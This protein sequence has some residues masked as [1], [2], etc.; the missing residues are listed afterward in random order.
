[1]A[2][3]VE[4]ES[5]RSGQRNGCRRGALT[6]TNRRFGLI[7]AIALMLMLIAGCGDDGSASPDVGTTADREA[8]P[9]ADFPATVNRTLDQ[10]IRQ[11][12]PPEHTDPVITPAVQVFYPGEGR[13]SFTLAE[14][15]GTEITDADVALYIAPIPGPGENGSAYEQPARG[16]FPA[17]LVS[18]GT[19][20]EFRSKTT[21]QNPAS[22][23]AFY[24]ADIPFAAGDWRVEAL[25]RYR[26]RLIAKSLPRA[27]VGAYRGIPKAGERPPA[28]ATPTLST[29]GGDAEK[30][31]TR[32]P[33]GDM[34]RSSFA[35][36]LG[37][38][39]VALLFT[40]PALCQSRV[41]SPVA[42]V[43]EQ[44]N[45]EFAGR[46]EMIQMEI[47]NG[48]DPDRGVRPQVRRFN[49]PSD[50]WLFIA[51]TNG[52]LSKAIEG[53]FGAGEMKRWLEEASRR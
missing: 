18:L 37:K 44:V 2:G 6:A 3:M 25:I 28:I 43:A 4:V 1:M 26:G 24:L 8:P 51:D 38:K 21:E 32:E 15:D 49:L 40:S 47:Y 10:I 11:A 41:C 12:D 46:V 35:E 31:T 19:E 42:D 39:P 34:H 29:A 14:R 48:N 5:R 45:R 13:Y 23:S 53:P 22:A 33:P 52:R 7:T 17:R 36:V 20:P 16:P 50:T 27:A 9:A 30:L